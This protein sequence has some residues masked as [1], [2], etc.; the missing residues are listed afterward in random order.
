MTSRALWPSG[1]AW[2]TWFAVLGAVH[3]TLLTVRDAEGRQA[4][5]ALIFLLVVLGGS[6]SGARG[7][8]T[9][10]GVS[11]FLLIN[12]YYQEPFGTLGV[13]KSIDWVVLVGFIATAV[14]ATHL[15]QVA[16]DAA[17]RANARAAEVL[18]LTE[19]AKRAAALEEADQLK[20]TLLASVSHDLRTPLAS[21]RALADEMPASPTAQ[22]EIVAQVERLE[23]MIRGIL[24]F[25]RIK[26]GPTE[27]PELNV[28]EDLIG[29][30]LRQA[31]G[32][33]RGRV[34]RAE[35]HDDGVLLAQFRFGD[36]LRA[37]TNLIENAA[38]H[39]PVQSPIEVRAHSNGALVEISVVDC[40]P[41]LPA[42]EEE[43]VFLPFYRP[44][45]A[46]PDGGNAGLGLAIAR[47]IVEQQGGTLTYRARDHGGSAFTLTLPQ[48]VQAATLD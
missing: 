14:V 37:L 21:I 11:G 26:S 42:G 19:E 41:G 34:V 5:I 23:R 35:I 18:A 24:D 36:T 20:D 28:V 33:L 9:A 6:A 8:G 43:R 25:S 38:R 40:G 4:H 2:L 44:A 15:V 30:A 48:A 29:A 10:L 46:P 13:A 31:D 7:L 47:R 27:P 12:Y 16:R 1:R 17:N 32:I 3:L 39:T 45:G 22:R